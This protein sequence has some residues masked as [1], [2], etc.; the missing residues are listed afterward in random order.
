MAASASDNA[1]VAQVSFYVDGV[2]RCTDT[3]APYT[4]AWNARKAAA[5]SHIIQAKAWDAAGNMGTASVTVTK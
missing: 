3:A 5:G 4:C 2:L 1:G